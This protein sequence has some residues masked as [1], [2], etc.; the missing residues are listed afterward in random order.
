MRIP[1]TTW[2][3]LLLS[4]SSTRLDDLGVGVSLDFVT[5]LQNVLFTRVW[6]GK[7]SQNPLLGS[8]V[9]TQLS[10]S[11]HWLLTID[12]ISHACF[13]CWP[14]TEFKMKMK[15]TAESTYDKVTILA[16]YMVLGCALYLRQRA[17][18]TVYAGNEYIFDTLSKHDNNTGFTS[19]VVVITDYHF[20]NQLTLTH[21]N[22][23]L[24][25]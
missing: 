8:A 23:Q 1:A 20:H 10:V 9:G 3:L 21:N 7:Q 19:E 14:N 16:N 17:A 5:F 12:V 13:A 11:E 25:Q 6:P 24:V 4:S 2:L 15:M 18:F 22:Q